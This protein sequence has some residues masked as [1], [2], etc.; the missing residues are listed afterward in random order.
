[1][2]S[3]WVWSS[4]LGP[5]SVGTTCFR[6]LDFKCS[7][8][9]LLILTLIMTSCNFTV[10][11]HCCVYFWWVNS[12]CWI[13]VH[14]AHGPHSAC[15]FPMEGT[16]QA[17]EPCCTWSLTHTPAWA[18]F[19]VCLRSGLP[20]WRKCVCFIPAS[21]SSLLCRAGP[22]S[23]WSRQHIALFHFLN[24]A[25]DLSRRWKSTISTPW[26]ERSVGMWDC[27]DAI[28]MWW[29]YIR[30]HFCRRK[31]YWAATL[32]PLLGTLRGF[33]WCTEHL[34]LDEYRSLLA[35]L[36]PSWPPAVSNSSQKDAVEIRS[37]P[38][39]T[40]DPWCCLTSL[41]VRGKVSTV[42]YKNVHKEDNV[43][44]P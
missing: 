12:A 1:M 18:S 43:E 21:P 44:V 20:R 29:S 16:R 11:P 6:S 24:F 35:S 22:L 40:P 10:H 17:P 37:C 25:T 34:P 9:P 33:G 38:S 13:I 42:V 36:L 4:S 15:P 41:R 39:S 30:E 2:E 5:G 7:L 32:R 28:R 31:F 27:K 19:Q 3:F 23:P 26:P 14:R 8:D